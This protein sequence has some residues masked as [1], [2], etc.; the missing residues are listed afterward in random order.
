MAS[1]PH[2]CT[3]RCRNSE[4]QGGRRQT[5]EAG[6]GSRAGQGRAGGLREGEAC[7]GD[8]STFP[9]P[10]QWGQCGGREPLSR[11]SSL[12]AKATA[13]TA[14]A[15]QLL[16][17]PFLADGVVTV[18]LLRGGRGGL[19]WRV[20]AGLSALHT[21]R[22][23]RRGQGRA[24]EGAQARAGRGAGKGRGRWRARP[25]RTLGLRRLFGRQREEMAA[26]TFRS[27]QGPPRLSSAAL[28]AGRGDRAGARALLARL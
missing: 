17:T 1:S 20:G 22:R 24:G 13:A 4:S 5:E 25:L 16:R 9:L 19:C 3:Q 26:E 21:K 10:H 23:A 27:A 11:Q 8:A 15:G 14:W 18:R 7:S 28:R 2:Q 6:Q 12:R